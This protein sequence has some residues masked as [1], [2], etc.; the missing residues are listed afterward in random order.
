MSDATSFCG[1][2]PE[3]KPRMTLISQ[4]RRRP[5]PNLSDHFFIS[6]ICEIRGLSFASSMVWSRLSSFR[7]RFKTLGVPLVRALI[8]LLL[9]LLHARVT[10]AQ[11]GRG[12]VVSPPAY[13]AWQFRYELFQMLLEERGLVVESSLDAALAAPEESVV[14]ML[15]K[16]NR[17]QV[18]DPGKLLPFVAR[19][20]TVLIACDRS[21]SM[22]VTANFVSGPITSEDARSEERRVGKECW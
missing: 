8:P 5:S 15:G 7:C 14:V 16:L 21:G 13:A 10:F 11:E 17:I 22:G 12:A 1:Q 2:V 6:A 18:A 19:G 3:L 9:V 4:I 20:G